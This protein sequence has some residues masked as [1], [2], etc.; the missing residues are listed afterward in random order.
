MTD[1]RRRVRVA[2]VQFNSRLGDVGYNVAGLLALCEQGAA[3]GCQLLVLPEMATTGYCLGSREA[4]QPYVE[5]VPGPTTERFAELAA[6][7]GCYVVV[8]LPEVEPVTGLYYNTVAL[9]GPAGVAGVMRKV[10][11]DVWDSY[12]LSA[13]NLGFPVWDTPV[14]RI[15]IQICMDACYPE[16]SRLAALQGVDFLCLP[17]AWFGE[18]A[19]AGDWFTRAYE[20]GAYLLAADRWGTESGIVFSG[21]SAVIGPEGEV[22]ACL[23]T[24]DGLA[25]ADLELPRPEAGGRLAQ[26]RPEHYQELVQSR[27]AWSYRF[28]RQPGTP[29][30]QPEGA[31]FRA[32]AVQSGIE[33]ESVE[34][35]RQQAE[36][37]VRLAAARGARLVVLPE[38]SFEA[39][40]ES[41][42]VQAEPIPGPSTDWAKALCAELDLHLVFGLAERAEGRTFNA[43]VLAGPRG[44][45]AVY[46][47]LHLSAHDQSW[48]TPGEGGW[49]VTETRLGC[50]GLMTGQDALLPESARCLALRDA[51]V[52]CAP[53]AVGGPLPVRL[54]PPL[55]QMEAPDWHLWRVRASENNT[56]VIFANRTDLGCMGASGIFGPDAY[57]RPRREM[58]LNGSEA[59]LLVL[60]I[61]PR[62]Y[63]DAQTP[64]PARTKDR[65]RMRNVALCA[66]LVLPRETEVTP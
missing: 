56:Y 59:G 18:A 10:H 6:R 32:A 16:S 7:H 63:L 52:I 26:R 51:D 57:R 55:G 42:G 35:A 12:R 3:A 41:A 37:Q 50:V 65:L 17:T 27:L 49:V 29:G 5:T 36:Q 31:A 14:G 24:G 19:P 9:V 43:A 44:V 45:A 4:L 38:L 60:D 40:P 8:G 28:A 23:P 25:M 66:P 20:N 13:G 47:K 22:L 1:V 62:D 2:A 46:R 21:G 15:G 48:A 64:N 30:H 58:L 53:S 34:A 33:A 39:R 11:P 61:D 54:A